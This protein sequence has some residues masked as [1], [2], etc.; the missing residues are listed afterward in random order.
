MPARPVSGV[1]SPRQPTSFALALRSPVHFRECWIDHGGRST[2]PLPQ[3]RAVRFTQ[4][5]QLWQE[6]TAAYSAFAAALTDFRRSQNDR[7]HLEQTDPRS[8]A[9][10]LAR[11]ESYRLRATATAALCRVRLICGDPMLDELAQ[12][13]VD[14]ATEIHLAGDEEDRGRRGQ[15]ARLALDQF[16]V[17]AS[18]QVQSATWS[19]ASSPPN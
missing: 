11:E 17:N 19:P 10:V 14:A 8:S 4:D 2:A 12:Q 3:R 6:R 13:A 5:Q 16:L 7:W 9:F 18:A 1:Y 15:R